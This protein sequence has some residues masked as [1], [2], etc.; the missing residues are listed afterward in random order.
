MEVAFLTDIEG[1][2]LF[3]ED[4]DSSVEIAFADAQPVLAVN[5]QS[6]NFA[7]TEGPTNPTDQ[8]LTISN[9]GTGIL[10]WTASESIPWLSLSATSGTAPST[11]SVSIDASDLAV[12][13]YTGEIQVA[14]GN[15][16]ETVSVHLRVDP[17][18]TD[19]NNI[20]IYLPII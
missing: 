15:Q 19:S 12:G 3:F 9:S 7:L 20:F 4:Q 13:N 18:G 10:N 1:I 8:T 17:P 2:P 6:L 11:I 16:T 14:A 5:T